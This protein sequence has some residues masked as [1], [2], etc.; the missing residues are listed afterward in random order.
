MPE[1][2]LYRRLVGWDYSK[3]ASLFV[4]IATEPR[5]ALFGRVVDDKVELSPLGRVVDEALAALSHDNPGLTLHWR[6][7]GALIKG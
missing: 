3:G 2:S 1:L 6:V 4:T 5:R 7:D